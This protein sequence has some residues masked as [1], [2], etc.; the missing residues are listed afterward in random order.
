M[1]QMKI[2]QVFLEITRN[3][4]LN[5][6]HCYIGEKDK[7]NEMSKEHWFKI[8]DRL[9]HFNINSCVLFGGEPTVHKQF[10]EI[11][12]YAISNF[13][14]VAVETSGV[15][16]SFLGNYDCAVCVS[17]ESF[18]KI[19]NDKIRMFDGVEDKSKK[20]K[21]VYDIAV[22]KLLKGKDFQN[23]KIIR[24]TLYSDT[25]VLGSIV[26]AEKLQANL[27]LTPLI[28]LGNASSTLTHKIPNAK[29]IQESI[30]ECMLANLKLKGYHQIQIP[31]WYLINTDLFNKYAP[32]FKKQKRI[33]SAGNQRLYVDFKGNVTPCMFL[34]RI[35]LGNILND[36]LDFIEKNIKF[37][38]S[39]AQEIEPQGNCKGCEC[40]DICHGGCMAE[41]INNH[42]NMGESCPL[43]KF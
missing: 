43:S 29:K 19:E 34:P 42:K 30:K 14:S 10:Y 20:P 39:E 3:C 12:S 9:K 13:R 38:N 17:F 5:C 37:F 28:N 18:K 35:K 11:L 40:W 33:C 8:I 22:K 16:K 36:E 7:K 24:M 25:D 21:S 31:Q 6:K 32:L 15:T 41:Y 1:T 26:M 4:P 27:V 2:N 23:E